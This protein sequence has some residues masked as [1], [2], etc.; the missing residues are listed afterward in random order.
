MTPAKAATIRQRAL[1]RPQNQRASRPSRNTMPPKNATNPATITPINS[2]TA[3][4]AHLQSH[5]LLLSLMGNPLD[6]RAI[7]ITAGRLTGPAEG[8]AAW[9][10]QAALLIQTWL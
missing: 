4:M 5:V 9:M 3:R 10:G 8:L 1:A 7:T 2:D 6:G